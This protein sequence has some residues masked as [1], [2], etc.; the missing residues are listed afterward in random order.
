MD[1]ILAIGADGTNV[2]TG[3]HGRVIRL[4]ELNLQRPLQ[5]F[6]CMFHCNELPLRH[7]FLHLDGATSGPRAFSGPLGKQLQSCLNMEVINFEPINGNLPTLQDTEDLSKDQ[8]YLFFCQSQDWYLL[9]LSL[10]NLSMLL[11]LLQLQQC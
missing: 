11:L 4:L 7:L 9:Q 10:H 2:Y 3:I 1:K 6:I 5:W 8:W